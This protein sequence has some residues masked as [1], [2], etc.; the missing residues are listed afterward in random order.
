VNCVIKTEIA[1]KKN[2]SIDANL[3]GYREG[4][5][6]THEDRLQEVLTKVSAI[7]HGDGTLALNFH[8]SYKNS[9]D[10]F[11]FMNDVLKKVG[12]IFFWFFIFFVGSLL[13]VQ[14]KII[15]QNRQHYYGIFLCKGLAWGD[16]YYVIWSQLV[17]SFFVALCVSLL[18]IFILNKV[19]LFLVGEIT[20]RYQNILENKLD[21]FPLLWGDYVFYSLLILVFAL[22][23]SA[24]LIGTM[25]QNCNEQPA[26]LLKSM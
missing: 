13:Y 26:H 19:S 5:I 16:L 10:R 12:S 23:I 1:P 22:L 15:I 9:L 2:I 11:S 8:P 3:H 4:F 20:V 21:I 24:Y 17:V 7:K 18:T 25:K 6:Y 14:I